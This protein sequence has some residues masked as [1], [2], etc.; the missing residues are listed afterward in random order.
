[1]QRV[2][3]R[4]I[5]VTLVAASLV[6]IGY[7]VADTV[8]RRQDI[9][10]S[11]PQI[12]P[13]AAQR[14]EDFHRVKLE[15]GALAWELRAKEAQYFDDDSV[16]VVHDPE[17]IFYSDGTEQARL[18]GKEGH[19]TFDGQDMT[20]V[21]LRGAVVVEGSGYVLETEQATYHRDRDVINAP[22]AVRIT[23]DTMTVLGTEMDIVVSSRLMTL[24]RDVRVT[25]TNAGGD[26]S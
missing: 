3:L 6:W 11:A 12:L 22:G 26:E 9:V 5:V 20:S 10:D 2:Q 15:H 21:E 1:M 8:S 13:N 4:L 19:L 7:R 24:H 23:S 16:A 18:R 25:I 17:M 14:L